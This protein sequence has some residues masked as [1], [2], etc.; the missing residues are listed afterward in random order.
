MFLD[1]SS[2]C[3]RTAEPGMIIPNSIFKNGNNTWLLIKR[4]WKMELEWINL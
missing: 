1:Y 2:V 4:Y 3:L